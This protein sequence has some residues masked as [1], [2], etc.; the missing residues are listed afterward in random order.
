MLD[1]ELWVIYS[2]DYVPSH[3]TNKIR[4][5]LGPRAVGMTGEM[6]VGP[7]QFAG[8]ANTASRVVYQPGLLREIARTK[9]DVLVGDG[10]FQ[11]TSFALIYKMFKKTPLVVCY[12]RTFHTERS[13]QWYRTLY[14]R[15]ALRFV[16]A[17]CC[18][19]RL[20]SEYSQ[21]LGMSELR[22]TTGHMVADTEKLKDAVACVSESQRK[23]LRKK[24]GSPGVV[25]L[26]VGRLNQRKGVRELLLG[27]SVLEKELPGQWKLVLIGAGPEEGALKR[28]VREANLQRVMFVG[29]V[30]YD[31]IPLYYAAADVLVMPT[32]EDNWSLVVPEAMACGLPVLCSKYNGCHPELIR[33]GENGWVFDPLDTEETFQTLKKC[34]ENRSRLNQM[35]QRSREIISA[36]T[37]QHAAAS[38]LS[39]CKIALRNQKT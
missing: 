22:I 39:A 6:R 36:H 34:I 38:I 20:C 4:Q 3:V 18:N 7:N 8:F 13:A 27:W 31:A 37:P 5:S 11:W 16:D 2:E 23:A 1:G 30:D 35:G 33:P 21:W 24:W 29:S 32:L 12:E 9:P 25:F 17:M 19:G 28:L 15:F 26:A 10:F 14:R